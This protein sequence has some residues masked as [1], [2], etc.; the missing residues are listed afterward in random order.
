M[1]SEIR[2]RE[3]ALS[4]LKKVL[5]DGATIDRAIE[6]YSRDIDPKDKGFIR[7]LTATTIRRLG[8]LDKIINHCTKTKLGNTQMAI[9]HVLRL[10][11]CQLLFTDVPAY[12]AVDT[13]VS[14]V[15][16]KVSKKLHYLK[17][18]VNAVLRKIDQDREL[19]LKKYG[20]T[21]LNFPAWLL[22]SWDNRYGQAT[23]KK[24]LDVLLHE[25]PLDL[26]FKPD[27]DIEKEA[28][29]MG[30]RL[31]PL[32]T[33]RLTKAG[34][35]T[36]VD[37]YDDGN[38]WVQDL[39]ARIP[40]LLLGAGRGD[41][42]LDLCA[43]PGGKTAQSAALGAIVTAIDFSESRLEKLKTNMERLNLDVDVVTSDVLKYKPQKRYGFVLLDAPCSSTGTIRRHPEILH[44][45]SFEEVKEL[46]I[47]QAKMLD[48]AVEL[49][50]EGG[51][52]IY[53]VCSME[54]LEGP[55]QINALLLRH[56]PLKRKE[57]KRQELPGLE[58]VLMESGDIQTLPHLIEGGMDGFFIS[59]L[60]KEL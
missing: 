45:R 20:N 5:D 29:K 60:T 23:V 56:S 3:I 54:K 34:K 22:D 58:A 46:S 8:Q 35:I 41:T 42:V 21:R 1:V 28:Q 17:N 59:R 33:V 40:A 38:W 53:S 2:S 27:M 47:L 25:A 19:L 50:K 30:G 39:A 12:A 32:N 24:I 11:V 37:G 44:S 14:L 49:L 13:S 9:R 10:G 7:N 18:M 36:D 52:L 15:D 6:K 57:I 31:L 43:A 51:T 26:S 4:V 48:H 55:D 16:R